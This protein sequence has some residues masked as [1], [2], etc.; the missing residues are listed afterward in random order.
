MLDI[1]NA[2]LHIQDQLEWKQVKDRVYAF[3]AGKPTIP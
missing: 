2:L 3:T 1:H